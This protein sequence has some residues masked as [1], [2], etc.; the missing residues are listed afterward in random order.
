[1]LLKILAP[2]KVLLSAKS[3]EEAALIVM[4]VEPL[5]PTPFMF[6]VVWRIVAVPA[7]PETLPVTLPVKLP[8]PLVKK[9]FVVEAVVAKKLVVVAEVPV[10][11]IKVKFWRVVEELARRLL[12]VSKAERVSLP[13]I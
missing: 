5:K 13:P 1:M 11:L 7:L 9:R 2:V 12:A 8:V 4:S 10:P 3:V 6:L